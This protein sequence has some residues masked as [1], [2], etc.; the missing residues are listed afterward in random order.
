MIA[1]PRKFRK[2]IIYIMIITIVFG[3]L[4]MGVTFI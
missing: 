3:T 2:L 1:V 4:L